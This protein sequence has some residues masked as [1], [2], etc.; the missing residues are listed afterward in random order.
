MMLV[1]EKY[2]RQAGQA[3]AASIHTTH[4]EIRS[5]F[6]EGMEP[7]PEALRVLHLGADL[8]SVA[9]RLSAIEEILWSIRPEFSSIGF[10][11]AK[12]YFANQDSSA[13]VDLRKVVD[14]WL[15]VLMRHNVGH[16]EINSPDPH[17]ERTWRFAERQRVIEE[18]TVAEAFEIL[19][20]IGAKLRANLGSGLVKLP[21]DRRVSP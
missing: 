10:R 8:N 3:G 12:Q 11:E 5:Y 21:R 19:R 14:T 13:R 9:V 7:N 6:A 18:L 17:S 15:H 1:A 4:G 16:E 20:Q 2:L